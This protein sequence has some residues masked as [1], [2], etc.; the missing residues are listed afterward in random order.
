M[1]R[2]IVIAFSVLMPLLSSAQT[3]AAAQNVGN[4]IFTFE[5]ACKT[6]LE[7][8]AAGKKENS[9]EMMLFADVDTL[10]NMIRLVHDKSE[11]VDLRM[12][13]MRESERYSLVVIESVEN[14]AKKNKK[15][16]AEIVR[17][18]GLD[19]I[20]PN[21]ELPYSEALLEDIMN[22]MDALEAEAN[23]DDQ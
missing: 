3:G 11:S 5:G 4:G 9:V 23:Q 22:A 2:L 12:D 20:G 6:K 15:L 21:G 19:K 16:T 18:C 7:A 10:N 13:M 1:V 8:L 17:T 14:M